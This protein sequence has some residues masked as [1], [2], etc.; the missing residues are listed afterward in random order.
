MPACSSYSLAARIQLGMAVS[1]S[2]QGIGEPSGSGYV[3]A[4]FPFGLLA[5]E[6]QGEAVVEGQPAVADVAVC[7]SRCG[8][9][10]L[11]VCGSGGA[12]RVSGHALLTRRVPVPESGAPLGVRPS[13][14]GRERQSVGFPSR[15]TARLR[16][17]CNNSPLHRPR[18]GTLHRLH[19]H[20]LCPTPNS[21]HQ[22]RT[23]VPGPM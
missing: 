2:P 13:S 5:L 9:S 17:G 6:E 3:A 12:T 10:P 16:L 19:R 7:S 22:H 21:R 8:P 15:Q 14:C 20:Y 4:L 11:G 1:R 23:L 18:Q